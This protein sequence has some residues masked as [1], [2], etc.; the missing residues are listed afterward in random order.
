MLYERQKL[1]IAMLDTLGGQVGATDFQKLLFLYTEEFEN[2]GTYDF[3]PYKLGCFSF[4]SYADKRKLIER[5]YLFDDADI[6][7]I[8]EEGKGVAHRSHRARATLDLF[9]QRYGFLRGNALIGEVYRRYPY[10]AIKSEIVDEVVKDD[11]DRERIEDA[12]PAVQNPGLLTIGYEGKSL[13]SYLNQLIKVGVSLLCDVRRNP[14]SRKYGFSKKTLSHAC[15]GVGIRYEHLPELGIA[16]A[17]RKNLKSQDDYDSL[18]S[19]YEVETLR[20][21]TGVIEQIR[22]WIINGRERVALTCYEL[23]PRQCHRQRVAWAIEANLG[24]EH[25]TEHL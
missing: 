13:E 18:F 10:F 6:W 23:N 21:Q 2:P 7:R 15:Q 14:V 24:K 1:L 9:R 12:R 25:K 11:V 19:A 17:K 16:S 5:G 20:H 8:T 3:V 22:K 4:T